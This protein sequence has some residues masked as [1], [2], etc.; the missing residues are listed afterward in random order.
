MDSLLENTEITIDGPEMLHC[1]AIMVQLAPINS[2][3][4]ATTYSLGEMT[5]SRGCN[6]QQ[7]KTE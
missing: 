2:F 1:A 6:D 3:K 7:V 4:K 5:L